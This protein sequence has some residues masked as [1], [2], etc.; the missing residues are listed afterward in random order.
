MFPVSGKSHAT[1][2]SS[3]ACFLS[4]LLSF[5]LFLFL[6]ITERGRISLFVQ[7]ELLRA[8]VLKTGG[9]ECRGAVGRMGELR[10]CNHAGRIKDHDDP[11]ESGAMKEM[12]LFPESLCGRSKR[13]RNL[14]A[15]V[16]ALMG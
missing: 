3:S 13:D 2:A 6:L 4:L 11:G 14:V 8:R 15:L 1:T 10:S 5:L 16:S 7:L 12:W 9:A